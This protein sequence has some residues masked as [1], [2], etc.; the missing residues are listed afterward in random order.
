MGTITA[1]IF[2]L[3]LNTT[4]ASLS[5]QIGS[6]TTL[7]SLN[8]LMSG[9]SSNDTASQSQQPALLSNIDKSKHAIYT[10]L[11]LSNFA[12]TDNI[13]LQNEATSGVSTIYGKYDPNPRNQLMLSYHYSTPM[14]HYWFAKSFG[15]TFIAPI[16]ELLMIDTTSS[17]LPKYYWY[18]SRINKTELL[19]HFVQKLN[20]TFSSSISLMTQWNLEGQ[21][22]VTAGLPSGAPSSGRIQSKVR[23]KLYPQLSILQKKTNYLLNASWQPHSKQKLENVVIG[24]APLGG[25]STVDYA[26][27]MLAQNHFEPEQVKIDFTYLNSDQFHLLLGVT[28]QN[29]SSYQSNRLLIMNAQGAII[30]SNEFEIIKG[31]SIFSPAI[32]FEYAKNFDTIWSLSYRFRPQV[33]EL[34]HAQSGNTL[35]QD[36]HIAGFGWKSKVQIGEES[37]EFS[38]GVQYHYLPSKQIAKST[39]QEDGTPGVKIGSPNYKMGGSFMLFGLGLNYSF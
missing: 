5:N 29:W 9:F 25:N 22:E 21:S 10:F 1:I 28:Y 38:T 13:A 18:D 27:T 34:D 3:F 24:K 33:L 37:M 17:F 36:T 35:D 2:L 4:Q 16:P 6:S 39:S 31:K 26:F 32:G 14:S 15:L 7:A 23:A 20:D 8:L 11:A 19:L 30:N 12:K